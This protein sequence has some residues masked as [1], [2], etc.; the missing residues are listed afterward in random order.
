MGNRHSALIRG[1]FVFA[2][3]LV[4]F[5]VTNAMP[6]DLLSLGKNNNC[7]PISNF[8]ARDGK[9]FPEF[10]NEQDGSGSSSDSWRAVFWCRNAKDSGRPYRLI[11]AVDGQLLH[12]DGCDPVLKWKDKPKGLRVHDQIMPLSMFFDLQSGKSVKESGSTKYRPVSD[13]Y[14]GSGVVFYCHNKRWLFAPLD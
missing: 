6:R 2:A 8:Y 3:L 14:D 5:Q 4:K 11:F 9:I 1:F 10:I 13:T 7:A 12:W